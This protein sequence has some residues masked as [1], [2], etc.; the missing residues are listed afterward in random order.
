[1]RVRQAIDLAPSGP[2]RLISACAG[3]G[4]DV[5]G[6]LNGHP[7][8]SDVRALLVELDP[9][10][11]HAAREGVAGAGLPEV[12]V[13]REDASLTASYR[14]AVPADVLLLCGIFG[15]ISNE[16]VH[17]TIDAAPRLCAPSAVVVWTRHRRSPDQTPLIRGWFSEAGFDELAFDSPGEG[18]FAV[19]TH[20][21]VVAPLGFAEDL[22]LFTF[23]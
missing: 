7:R 11:V 18:R 10:N 2:V 8:A 5:I 4:R 6:A 1:M 22:R 9:R 12:E 21:L 20:R 3:Q 16:D 15:N 17:A 13:V 19:G 23:L 14:D